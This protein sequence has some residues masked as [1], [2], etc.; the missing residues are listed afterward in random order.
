MLTVEKMHL[1][2]TRA[3]GS[4]ESP[5]AQGSALTAALL[6]DL[7]EAGMIRIEDGVAPEDARVLVIR[8][9][10]TTHP[11]LDA[12]LGQLDSAAG[13]SLDSMVASATPDALAATREHLTRRGVLVAEKSLFSTTYRPAS[14]TARNELREDL[15]AVYRGEREA[16]GADLLLLGTLNVL[17]L[18]RTLL[19]EAAR[20]EERRETGRALSRLTGGDLFVGAVSRAVCGLSGTLAAAAL[21]SAADAQEQER[22]RAAEVE[23]APDAHS[24]LDAA[25]TYSDGERPR[26]G[27]TASWANQGERLQARERAELR[28]LR[29]PAREVQDAARRNS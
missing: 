14:A 24:E 2:L 18:A 9:G 7:R 26:T 19:P 1:L 29:S 22:E 12:V 4:S 17:N 8:G 5:S 16:T 15:T 13:S 27:S 11:L 6:L 21:P 28:D 3:D 10:A 20:G 25:G 23:M